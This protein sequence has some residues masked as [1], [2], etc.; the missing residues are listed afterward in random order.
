[1]WFHYVSDLTW[2]VNYLITCYFLDTLI[3]QFRDGDISAHFYDLVKFVATESLCFHE[4]VNKRMTK[5]L[6]YLS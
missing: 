4:F 6:Y 2:L 3:S 5:Q 1:M